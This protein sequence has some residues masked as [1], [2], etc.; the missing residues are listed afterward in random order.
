M[1]LN[2]AKCS[3]CGQDVPKDA[4]TLGLCPR[5]LL[6]SALVGGTNVG[7]RRAGLRD[8]EPPDPQALGGALAGL[9]VLEL[10]GQ[11]GMGFVY[12]AR[13]RS[14]DRLVAVKL[15][16]REA[17][18]DPSFAERFAKEARC[19]ANLSHPTILGACSVGEAKYYW[20]PE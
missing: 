19:L 4:R 9:E 8:L 20:R 14:L 7:G 6:R 2:L 5:C 18:A 11:G 12:R 17:Y 16:P 15:F 3:Q 10:I 13:Q 1:V